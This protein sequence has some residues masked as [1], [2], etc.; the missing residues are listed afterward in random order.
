M[1][2]WDDPIPVKPQHPAP[3]APRGALAAGGPSAPSA[4]RS[5][6]GAAPAAPR[7]VGA[8]PVRG[9]VPSGHAI[10]LGADGAAIDAQRVNS[11]TLM[12]RDSRRVRVEDKRIINA[13]ADVNQLVPFKYKWAWEKYLAGCANHWMPQEI[14]LERDIAL[15]KNPGGLSDD[16]NDEVPAPLSPAR[17]VS[18]NPVPRIDVL[19]PLPAAPEDGYFDAVLLGCAENVHPQARARLQSQRPARSRWRARRVGAAQP[20]ARCRMGCE[21]PIPHV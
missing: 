3:V 7:P 16:E 5:S 15:W 11:G 6:S 4:L 2:S 12:S 17:A 18:R 9:P 19:P 8:T 21:R 1:L 13:A 10:A 14:N 20:P